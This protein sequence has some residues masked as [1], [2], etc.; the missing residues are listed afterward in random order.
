MSFGQR[1]RHLRQSRGLTQS[2][3][4]GPELSKSFISLL[5]K[6]RTQPSIETL[7]LIARRL[8]ASVDSLLGQNGRLP[9]MVC[10]G[11]LALSREA[12][13]RH[14]AATAAR[15]LDPASFLASS[16]SL[17]EVSRE[18]RLLEGQ[19]AL[20]ARQLAD[21]QIALEAAREAS[22]RAGDLWRAGRALVMLGWLRIRRRDFPE[23]RRVLDRALL[24]LRRARAGRDPARIDALLAMGTTLGN[25]GDYAGAIRRYEEAA[26]SDVAQRAPAIRGQALWGIGQAHRKMG[27]LATAADYLLQARDALA[28]AEELPD[29]MR[30]LKALGQLLAEQG[31]YREALRHLHHALR[32]MD[33]L[34]K[35]FDHASAMTEIGRVQLAMGN[36]DDAVH[37]ATQAL[38]EARAVGDPVEA[39]EASIVL[40]RASLTHRDSAGAIRL[41]K[42]ALAAFRQREMAGKVAVVARELGLLLR[43]RGAHAQAA[44]YLAL[45][46]EEERKEAQGTG[47]AVAVGDPQRM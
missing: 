25:L 28:M 8:G 40:A 19:M 41:Y 45:S 21:A 26:R 14:D 27:Q 10:E 17:A 43:E 44:E 36:L 33:R 2:Q 18:V 30:V 46:L 24:L 47:P 5:E 29:L 4:G 13:A 42:S 35:R 7:L 20:D 31:R 23:A 3:L 39:A 34:G 11:L 32:V 16:Y 38:E 15:L 22:E 12:L 1:I 37:F 9:D 6:D